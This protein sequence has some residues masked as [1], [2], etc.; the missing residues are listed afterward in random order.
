VDLAHVIVKSSLVPQTLEDC[1]K[2][3]VKAVVVNTSGFREI[4]GEGI[5]LEKKIVEIATRTGMR[6]FGP[7]C[8]GVMNTAADVSLYSNFTFAK[9]RPGNI[10]LVFQGGGAAEVVNNYLAM[11]GIGIKMYASPGNACDISIPEIIEYYGQDPDTKVIVVQLESLEHPKEFIE[12]TRKLSRTKPILAIKSGTTEEGAKAVSS[13]T[14]GMMQQDTTVDIVFDKCGIIRFETAE[15]ICEAAKAFATQPIPKGGNLAI[16]TNAGSPAILS[17]D[18]AV[19]GGLKLPPPSDETQKFLKA[20]LFPMASVHN[21]VDMMATAEPK[22]FAA[23]MDALLKDEKYHSILINFITPFFVDCVGVAKEIA[24]R[25]KTSD[26]TIACVAMT[27]EDWAETVNIVK[28]SG[29]PTYYFPEAATKALVAMTDYSKMRSRPEEAPAKFP[30]ETDKAKKILATAQKDANGFMLAKDCFELLSCYG[31]PLA[32]WE[33]VNSPESAL[34]A[35]K[36]MGFPVALKVDAKDVV[37]KTESGGVALNL[38]ND[39][40]LS[41]AVKKM[42]DKFGKDAGFIVQE[43]LAGGKELIIGATAQ[44]EIGH[45]VMFGLGGIYVEIFKDVTFKLCPVT[46]SEANE[47]VEGI[48]A[49]KLLKGA[50]GEKPVDVRKLVEILQRV[51]QMLT[52][53]PEIK[54]LDLNPVM[55]FDETRPAKAADARIRV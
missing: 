32:K 12:V 36:K 20:N 43:F 38:K 54:E 2:K 30:A 19:K 42:Q 10:S 9:I 46:P 11:N 53:L 23:T 31:I 6:L 48:K 5:E 51:S 3:G 14:G 29:I 25:A 33:R 52:E 21:P 18:E 13:H 22:H 55:A 26:K 44:P 41:A 49:Q 7:N 15:E 39:G 1:A 47:M 50:R 28:A 35:A 8:Q 37:H 40:E 4:G 34:A 24:A 16:V 45:T 17:T 27:N